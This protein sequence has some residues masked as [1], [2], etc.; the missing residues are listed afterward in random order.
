MVQPI[1]TVFV[2]G[3]GASR[4][5]GAPLM[6]DFLD[7]AERLLHSGEVRE[8]AHAFQLVFRAIHMLQPAFA[9]AR[10]DTD[11]LESV[12]AAFEMAR[13]FGRLGDLP[14]ED[15][16]RLPAAM[17][18]VIVRTL[19]STVSF[20][21]GHETVEAPSAYRQL[22]DLISKLRCLPGRP[23]RV[24]VI[25]FNYDLALD[26][27]LYSARV[28]VYYRLSSQDPDAVPLLKL[29]G[30]I[31][32]YRGSDGIKAWTMRDQFRRSLWRIPG[33]DA[34]VKL[35][36]SVDAPGSDETE[37]RTGLR[38]PFIVPPAWSKVSHFED[39]QP[40][41]RGA[42]DA[43][44]TAENIIVIGYS[45]PETDGF[46]RYLYA[47]GTMSQTRLK[48]FLL[49]DPFASDNSPLVERYRDVIGSALLR[50]QR[51][52]AIQLPFESS[53]VTVRIKSELHM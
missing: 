27:A 48:R 30:S 15:L 28:P 16:K 25:T 14:D 33:G 3:A 9:K 18:T 39:I 45:M 40:V 1:G 5:A 6:A 52:A 46:F 51:F 8:D 12:Y 26:Y 4:H 53:A 35:R 41:W 36:L 20:V 22:V 47:L 50:A 42:A 2:L 37:H 13:V 29:H 43:F 11:N 31:N 49:F 24:S 19:E 23:H 10:I 7:V 17:R 38:D 44:S 32:W 34:P 21:R